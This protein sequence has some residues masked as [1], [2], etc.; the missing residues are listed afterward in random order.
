MIRTLLIFLFS[1]LLLP[2]T[3]A[4]FPVRVQVNVVQPV[5]PY[6]PQIKADIAGN[7]AGSLNQ[8]I[9]SHIS[10]ILSY[11]GRNQQHIKLAGSIQRVAPSPIGVSLRPDF[12]PAQPIIMGP[13]QAMISL[14]SNMLQNAF[15]NFQENSLI[16]TNTDLNTL[17]QNGIDYK[18]PEGMYRVCVTAYDYDKAGFSAPLSAPGTGCAYFTI[19][20]TASAP[21]LILP[22]STM[23]QSNSGFQD[24]VPHSPQIQF[25]WTPPATTC[26]M[27]LGALTYD[28]EIRRVFKIGRA[29]V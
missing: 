1:A 24:F 2:H 29:H 21:Q 22:V 6:L 10:I 17:R 20:Y 11:T 13:Q 4:Q 15:G 18:L 19:C 28:L 23:L 12:Q 16:Y 26:G 25:V 5:P 14:T 27:P 9:S 8:D 3:Q 7:R